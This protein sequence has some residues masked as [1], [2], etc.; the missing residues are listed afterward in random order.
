[1]VFDSIRFEHPQERISSAH[2]ILDWLCIQTFSQ[3]KIVKK[4]RDAKQDFELNGFELL[5]WL[6]IGSQKL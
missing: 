5:T 3:F 6:T 2:G 4:M 1:M